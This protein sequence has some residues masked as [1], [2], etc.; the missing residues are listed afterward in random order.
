MY[1]ADLKSAWEEYRNKFIIGELD[2]EADWAAYAATL[3]GFGLDEMR[4]CYQSV[5]DRTR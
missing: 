3:K 2:V 4:D 5:Y 1:Q